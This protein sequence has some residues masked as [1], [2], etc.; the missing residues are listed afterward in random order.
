M[1]VPSVSQ[2]HFWRLK[3]S[4]KYNLIEFVL[5]AHRSVAAKGIFCLFLSFPNRLFL[6]QFVKG[7]IMHWGITHHPRNAVK[8]SSEATVCHLTPI[9]SP[10][11]DRSVTGSQTGNNLNNSPYDVSISL[12]FPHTFTCE[13][14]LKQLQTVAE[15]E[16]DNSKRRGDYKG[17]RSVH[18]AVDRLI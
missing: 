11:C 16:N 14:S 18:F 4:S 6:S 7:L 5:F 3:V 8:L 15:T 10:A 1:P 17:R 9:S 13:L 12:P 2:F